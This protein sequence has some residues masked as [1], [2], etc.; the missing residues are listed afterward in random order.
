MEI[1]FR[2]GGLAVSIIQALTKQVELPASGPV[3]LTH[4]QQ[5]LPGKYVEVPFHFDDILH[6]LQKLFMAVFTD[7]L[8]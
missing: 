4:P 8:L 6:V 1:P 7:T 5:L 2:M 3:L